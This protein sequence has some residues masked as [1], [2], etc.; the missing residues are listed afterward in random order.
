MW[1]LN[2]VPR[3]R[4]PTVLFAREGSYFHISVLKKRTKQKSPQVRLSASYGFAPESMILNRLLAL[5][6]LGALP[7]AYSHWNWTCFPIIFGVPRVDLPN[8]FI[9]LFRAFWTT[10]FCCSYKLDLDLGF[11]VNVKVTRRSPVVTSHSLLCCNS[12]ARK[13]PSYDVLKFLALFCL[14][15]LPWRQISI[16][17]TTSGQGYHHASNELSC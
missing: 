13:C 2:G 12:P 7:F 5:E 10:K 9:T 1:G 4:H 16:F 17:W 15:S 3:G 8:T 14:T 6:C 11:S